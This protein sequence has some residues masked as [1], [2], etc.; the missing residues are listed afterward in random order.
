M[1]FT[2]FDEILPKNRK[3]ENGNKRTGDVAACD[4][5]VPIRV[6]RGCGTLDLNK[7]DG[8][9]PPVPIRVLKTERAG[10]GLG[11]RCAWG[12]TAAM[13][14]PRP[15]WRNYE[16]RG[17]GD[18]TKRSRASGRAWWRGDGLRR[19]LLLLESLV[20]DAPAGGGVG[21]GRTR[22]SSAQTQ[23]RQ[24]QGDAQ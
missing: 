6:D 14:W 1:E 17:K 3:T 23:T 10:G 5:S 15:F 7:T 8:P 2:R 11:F 22:R 19:V 4:W 24:C 18:V 16:E 12:P 13:A 20:G 9:D 21:R